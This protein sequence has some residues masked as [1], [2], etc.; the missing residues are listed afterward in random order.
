MPRRAPAAGLVLGAVLAMVAAP[1]PAVASAPEAAPERAAKA[2]VPAAPTTVYSEDFEDAPVASGAVRLTDYTGAAP[3]EQTYNAAGPWLKDCNGWVTNR[4]DSEGYQPAINDCGS[5]SYWNSTRNL[6]A[7]LGKLRG[8]ADPDANHAVGGYT[9]GDPGADRPEF[10]GVKALTFP[11]NRFLAAG[12]NA[13]ASHCDV[14]APRLRFYLRDTDTSADTVLGT[15]NPCTHPGAV[16]I[17]TTKAVDAMMAPRLYSGTSA[18]LRMN[19]LEGSGTGNDHAFDDVRLLDVSPKVSKAFSPASV[20]VGGTSKLTFTVTNTTDLEAKPGWSFTDNLP[21]GMAAVPGST[22]TTCAKGEATAT[23]KAVR[24]K[25]DLDAGQESCTLSV[26]VTAPQGEYKNCPENIGDAK[27]VKKPAECSSVTFRPLPTPKLTCTAE[28]TRATQRYWYFG[29]KAGIDFGPSG[30]KAKALT[31]KQDAMEGTTVVTDTSGV[32]QFWS[33]GEG[34]YDRDNKPMPNGT[35][36][37]GNPSATQTVSAFPAPGQPGKYYVVTTDA[38][39]KPGNLTYSLVDMSLNGGRGDV[40]SGKKNLSLGGAGTASEALTAAPSADGKTFWVLTYSYKSPNILAYRFD[41]DGPVTGEPVVSKLPTDNLQ[42]Y[43]TLNFSADFKKLAALTGSWPETGSRSFVRMLRFN[44]ESGEVSQDS[45]WDLPSTSGTYGYSADFSPSGD[46]VYA[47]RIFGAGKLFRYRVADAAAGAA[48]KATEQKVGEIGTGGQVRRGPDGRMYVANYPNGALHV[49]NDPDSA[50][51]PGFAANGFP[52][53][54]GTVSQFGLPQTVTGCPEPLKP[55]MKISKA[56]DAKGP[57]APGDKV[58]YTLK[59]EN[60]GGVTTEAP[61][62][63]D[64]TKVVD[65]ATYNG[66][67]KATTGTASYDAPKLTWKPT[68]KPGESATLT[69]SVK[70]KDPATGDGEFTNTVTGPE[71]SNCVKGDED[72]C[73]TKG[74][75]NK[76]PRGGY[77]TDTGYLVQWNGSAYELSTFDPATGAKKSVGTL[78]SDKAHNVSIGYSQ[79]DGYLY[80]YRSTGNELLRIDPE[81][82]KSTST[83]ITGMDGNSAAMA[84]TSRDGSKLYVLDHTTKKLYTIDIDTHS[85][86]YAS[87]IATKELN[88]AHGSG[89]IAVHPGDGMLYTAA[90]DGTL[91]R[92]DPAT[93]DW[94]NLGAKLPSDATDGGL[95]GTFQVFADDLGELYFYGNF[96]GGLY[97]L[98][99]SASTADAPISSDEIGDWTRIGSTSTASNADAAGCLRAHD[100]GDAPNSYGTAKG[101]GPV[102]VA[103]K[104]LLLGAGISSERDAR[105]PGTGKAFD[106]T[107]DTMDDGVAAWPKLTE[108]MTSYSVPVKLANK[109]GEAATLTAWVD[110]DGSGTFDAGERVVVPVAAGAT[111][112]ELKWSGISGAA[113]AGKTYARLRLLN[114]TAAGATARAAAAAGTEGEIEDYPVTV[115]EPAPPLEIA[116]SADKTDA[117]PGDK[118]TYKLTVTNPGK[119][120]VEGA[121]LSDDLTGVIDDA[122]YNDDAKATAGDVTYKKPKLT[123]TGDVA[124]DSTVTITYTVT[125][126]R[127]TA[128]GDQK[129]GNAVVGPPDSNCPEGSTDPK[130]TTSVPVAALKIAKSADKAG[131]KPGDKVTYTVTVTNTGKAT[132]DDAKVSD[133]LSGVVDDAAYNDDA[134]ATSGDVSY[135]RPKLTWSGDLAAGATA[136]VTYT[137]TVGSPPKGDG[138]LKNVVTGPPGSNC[139]DGCGTETPVAELDIAKKADKKAAEPGDK[140]TYTVTVTNTGE[141]A[142]KGAEI[143]DDLTKVLDDAAYN[144]DAKAT[145]GDVSYER[146]KLTW[147]GDLAAGAKATITYSVTVDSPVKGDKKLANVVSGPPGSNCEDGCGTETPV[148]ALEFEKTS[149]ARKPVHPGDKVTYT[150]TVTNTGQAAYT[151]ASFTDDLTKVIDDATYNGDAKASSGDVAYSEPKLTWNGDV[152]AGKKVTVTYSVNVFRGPRTTGDG[153]LDNRIAG[154]PGSNCPPGSTDPKC[155]T[156]TGDIPTLTIK[157]TSDTSAPKPGDT[158]DYRVTVTN[159]S[160]TSDYKGASFTDNLSGLIDDATYNKDAAATSGT[161]SYEEPKLAWKGDVAAGRTVTLTYSVTVGAPPA[162][163]K[164]LTN[165]VVSKVPGSNCQEGSDDP[166]CTTDSGIPTLKFK[167]TATPRNPKEGDTLSYKVVVTND[168]QAD[169]TGATFTDD[170]TK[171][172]DDATYNGDADASSGSVSY[173]APKLT[174][175]G[176]LAKGG[177][178]TVTYT[179]TVTDAGDGKFVNGVVGPPGSNCPEGGTD[180]DCT[181][182]FPAPDYDF[183]DAP[184][185]YKTRRVSGGAFHELVDGLRIGLRADPERDG[186]PHRTAGDDKD[187]DGIRTVTLHQHQGS[188]TAKVPVTNTTG[189]DAVLA[190]WI[191]VDEN[192]TF[193]RDELASADVPDGATEATL[194]WHGLQDMKPGDTFARLR[195]FGDEGTAA[196]NRAAARAATHDIEPTGFGGPGEVEDHMVRVEPAHLELAKSASTSEPKPGDTVTYTVTVGSSSAAEYMGAAFTDDLTEVLDDATYNRDAEATAGEV[197]YDKPKLTWTGNVPAG[198]KVTI[199]YSVTVDDPV[200]G[201]RTLTNAVTGPEDSTCESGCTTTAEVP[202]GPNPPNATPTPSTPNTPT[203]PKTPTPST[204]ATPATPVTPVTPA[205]P[206]NPTP[207]AKP[208]KPG[209]GHLSDT[210]SDDHTVALAAASALVLGLGGLL[211]AAVRRSR[212]K[213]S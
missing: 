67:A 12:V 110:F 107:G 65:D 126:G 52:L 89:D 207:P 17:G 116:K 97:Q 85:S 190:G 75:V 63:D 92:L 111:S 80:G 56:S 29:N 82:A 175:T 41:G 143:S 26:D 55:E 180:P 137:V 179:F 68:L 195:L 83:K 73:T 45:Q 206:A 138:T 66:D 94:T 160:D 117:K 159:N 208:G 141:A 99:L 49:V 7:N 161:V 202:P 42:G 100:Y 119:A 3:L 102:A 16:D 96:K 87:V 151:G 147:S 23:G 39:V 57:V 64:L 125:V 193:E 46:Y 9:N 71:F 1:L 47:T 186:D 145:S 154:P 136:T 74:K 184:D 44:A 35:G 197:S 132:Y 51:A 121:R 109:T 48:I 108:D 164:K 14:A 72:G 133:D 25:G 15:V 150:V 62:V 112:A 6:A 144:G 199:T 24:L 128:D 187:D 32:L 10:V 205:T 149:D 188:Y 40:V 166:D 156:S 84:A 148:A 167:K 152:P 176:D 155:H 58:T 183:G 22:A 27:G 21:D 209:D 101:D 173:A 106:A 165:V 135:E 140:V 146:P 142:Y 204:P 210:G 5:E 163:D 91:W 200:K 53:P 178:A 4:A 124:A 70:V 28:Q 182:V 38:S 177:T 191:D 78:G 37:K 81:T 122:T 115:E 33:D 129:L 181:T 189:R 213:R 168:G 76:P 169:Y 171:V 153:K 18:Q 174:W 95:P 36:L 2:A 50:S 43:G 212:R 158:V 88:G 79:L 118:V 131:A 13:V 105:R 98:D 93:G 54:S 203:P 134:K 103:G 90:G 19:N 170:L 77:C 130:C 120:A 11:A 157:K 59:A 201:D 20:A 60:T 185:T 194:T 211:L 104:S 69:Y 113:K 192:G 86:T 8:D 31:G 34:V 61:V 196:A 123:W 127:P 30:T 172:L 162:G 139:P 114:G 198:E